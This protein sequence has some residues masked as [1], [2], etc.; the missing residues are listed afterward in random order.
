MAV[1]PNDN[2][3]LCNVLFLSSR[4]G[5]SRLGEWFDSWLGPP[6]AAVGELI[7]TESG[8]GST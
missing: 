5:S 7:G 8:F 2:I 4:V 6:L 1:V 3:V